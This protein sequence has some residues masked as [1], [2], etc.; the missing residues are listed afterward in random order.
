MNPVKGSDLAQQIEL[1][2]QDIERWPAWL[3]EAAAI[4]RK[5]PV[6]ISP[7][8]KPAAR[9]ASISDADFID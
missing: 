5:E 1:A 6:E 9:P 7:E 3:K 8:Q 2:R 4:G